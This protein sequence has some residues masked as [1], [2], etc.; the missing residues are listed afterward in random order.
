MRIERATRRG[1]LLA[2]LATA[3]CVPAQ[4]EPDRYETGH[5]TYE[6]HGS[7]NTHWI[8]T[9]DSVIVI[10]T[11]RDTVHAAEA[12]EA[13][14]A[15][16]KPVSAILITHG[17]PDHYTGIE[18]FLEEWPDAEV[19]GSRE[20]ARV[21]ETDHYGYHDVVREL[22]PEAAPDNFIAP[23]VVFEDDATL[24]IDGVTLVT[25][26]MGA[27]EATGATI[28]YLPQTRE[29]YAGDLVLNEMHGFY[30]EERSA[31]V[32]RALERLKVLFPNAET[33]HPGHGTPGPASQLVAGTIDY[34]QYAREVVA[35]SIAS[36]NTGPDAHSA[37][38]AE[39]N[40]AYPTYGV[41][42]GQPDMIALSVQGLFDELAAEPVV[43]APQ[44]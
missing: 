26:E 22:A 1:L 2:M 31:E 36:G 41:P 9:D 11:Q 17:H 24:T 27:A 44:L 5:Y 23:T 10:D 16:G 3:P 28:Y 34:T 19:Y 20:T 38:V 39:L 33:V 21:I 42:G 7:V 4:A 13:V 15:L 29:L 43:E 12:L 6:G 18:Q 30:L 40:A 37:V 32:L 35:R 8:E 25:R 14:R